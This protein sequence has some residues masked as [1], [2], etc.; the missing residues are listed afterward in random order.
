MRTLWIR[1]KLLGMEQE[2]E[3]TEQTPIQNRL[4]RYTQILNTMEDMVDRYMVDGV[5]KEVSNRSGEIQVEGVRGPRMPV[6]DVACSSF[7]T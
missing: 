7:Y 6:T 4:E 5:W 1:Y 3:Q 2:M